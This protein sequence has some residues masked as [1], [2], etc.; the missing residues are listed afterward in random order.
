[1]KGKHENERN[2]EDEVV[3]EDCPVSSFSLSF[4]L[5]LSDDAHP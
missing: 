5:S 2:D 4:T 3:S 1:M